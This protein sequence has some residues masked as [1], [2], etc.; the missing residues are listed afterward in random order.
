MKLDPGINI[1]MHSV[2]SIKPDVTESHVE[3]EEK[4]CLL[5]S[6]HTDAIFTNNFRNFMRRKNNSVHQNPS[7]A[8]K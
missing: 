2:L 8:S 7:L 3:K 1:V 6:Q 5:I 4:I